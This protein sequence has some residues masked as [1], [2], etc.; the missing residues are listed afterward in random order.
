ML[1]RVTRC[2]RDVG[3]RTPCKRI[4]AF[5]FGLILLRKNTALKVDCSTKSSPTPAHRMPRCPRLCYGCSAEQAGAVGA[6]CRHHERG[7]S[8][9]LLLAHLLTSCSCTALKWQN[10]WVKKRHPR[11]ATTNSASANTALR[12][13]S[14]K[15]RNRTVYLENG[16]K[17]WRATE[18][19]SAPQ[20]HN[21]AGAAAGCQ[22]RRRRV[23]RH[24]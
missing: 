10:A 19:A 23:K 2:Q 20:F 13:N 24:R 21:V 15:S 16:T 18:V 6:V 5:R 8:A 22:K 14:P 1:I 12:S 17:I 3:R 9:A 7:A 11:F 4:T